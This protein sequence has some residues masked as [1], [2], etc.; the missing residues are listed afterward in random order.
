ML[1]TLFGM[2]TE[3]KS[4]QSENAKRI[5][6]VTLYVLALYVTDSGIMT[7]PAY[8]LEYESGELPHTTRLQ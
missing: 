8:S 5:I 2:V 3:V 6:S 4:L 7:L 1:V